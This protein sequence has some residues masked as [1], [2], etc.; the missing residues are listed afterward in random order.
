MEKIS[1]PLPSEKSV[2]Q[3]LCNWG[4]GEG[5]YIVPLADFELLHGSCVYSSCISRIPVQY[6]VNNSDSI[7]TLVGLNRYCCC[8]YLNKE[9]SNF[10]VDKT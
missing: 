7:L 1:V 10:A 9:T 2:L 3:V 5:H 6:L 4:G 8:F